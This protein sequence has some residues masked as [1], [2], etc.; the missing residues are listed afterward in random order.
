[1]VRV[2]ADLQHLSG[3]VCSATK[4]CSLNPVQIGVAGLPEGDLG[5]FDQCFWLLSTL[6]W[7]VDFGRFA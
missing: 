1:M 2:A 6:A 7:S 4:T 3:H 5:W